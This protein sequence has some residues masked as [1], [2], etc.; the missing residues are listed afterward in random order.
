MRTPIITAVILAA[1]TLICGTAAANTLPVVGGARIYNVKVNSLAQM[2][3]KR[4][5]PQSYDLSCGAAAI[6]TLFK[7]YYG[8]DVDEQAV[9]D[10]VK[11]YGNA[12]EIERDGFS[13]LELKRYGEGR[14]YLAQGFKI[15]NA[16]KL[17]K[18]KVPVLT[19]INTRGYNHFVVIKGVK[20]GTVFIADPAF[21][22]RARSLEDFDQEWNNVILV[23]L[24]A[25]NGGQSEFTL[26]PILRG[27]KSEVQWILDGGLFNIRPG[28]TEF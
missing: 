13:M 6:A 11:E 20:D 1:S 25:T 12:E 14:G 24:S 19:L 26:D 3:F 22:N 17:S 8:E 2:K 10:S 18:L 9:I 16:E 23:F 15:K 5:V 28:P 4:V 21:G 27:R 7:Y